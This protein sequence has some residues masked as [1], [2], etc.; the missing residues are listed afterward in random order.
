MKTHANARLTPLGRELLCKRVTEAGWTLGAA[1]EA[2]GVSGRTAAKW[3]GR[4]RA[5]GPAGLVDR[6][7]AP[8]RIP[9]RTPADRVEAIAW[10]RRLR[11]TAA[12]ITAQLD[13]P[14]STVGAVLVRLRL[15]SRDWTHL[16]RPIATS[17][18]IPVSCCIS[19]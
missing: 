15:N 13:M 7:S 19:T 2:S 1:A 17:G 16:S 3:V 5:D 9:H 6:S 8:G 10:L 11:L 14:L 18:D 12:Q 4:Y